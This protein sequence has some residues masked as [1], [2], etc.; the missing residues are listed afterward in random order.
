MRV[1][2]GTAKGRKLMAPSAMDIRPTTDRM[3]E[4]LF[5]VLTAQIPEARFLDVFSGTG[6]IG[7]EAL[8]R[9]AKSAVLVDAASATLIYKNLA[10]TGF[11]DRAIV[12]SYDFSVA[13]RKLNK[14]HMEFDIVFMDPPYKK[15]YAPRAVKL[16]NES[17][18]LSPQGSLVVE[19]SSD[20][21]LPPISNFYLYKTKRYNTS[22]FY[23]LERSSQ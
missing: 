18:L 4:N 5:N 7:I 6:A 21:V 17:H 3:K 15:G 13:L 2:A 11:T 9:G 8:S 19:L 1:I 20:E 22:I 16:I 12:L 10:I 23:F 14:E